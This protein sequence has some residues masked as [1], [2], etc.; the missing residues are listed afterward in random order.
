MSV[1]AARAQSPL[2]R[3]WLRNWFLICLTLCIVAGLSLGG[4]MDSGWHR[5]I[6]SAV[7]G[8][9]P[10]V[11]VAVVLMLMSITLP[12]DDL[13]KALAS[14]GPSVWACLVNLL[15]IPLL[16]WPLSLLQT[17]D[18]FRLGL[19]IAASVPTTMAAASVWTRNAGGNDAVSLL[20]TATTN[21]LCFLVSPFWLRTL[22][23]SIVELDVERLVMSLIISALIPILLGQSL[24]QLKV[25]G[26]WVDA[27]KFQFGIVAQCCILTLVAWAAFQ[28]GPD[29][30]Q[31]QRAGLTGF[32]VVGLCCIALH[33]AGMGI[34]IMGCRGAG[35]SRR[36]MIAVAFAGSQKT[37]PIG[38]L[39]SNEV[40][41]PLALFPML[42]FHASQ[43]FI[44]TPIAMRFAANAETSR[45][46]SDKK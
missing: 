38:I 10:K 18:D 13:K 1:P 43:L 32:A 41:M 44:D 12:T 39:L 45:P 23:G 28:G 42:M 19:L 25:V 35:F 11:M 26:R 34:A 29:F 8:G 21:S 22:G 15:I 5:R 33:L 4:G 6:Q 9:V 40:G 36:D 7:G 20:V 16:A 46:I 2:R 31:G 37:L 24:R 14:P 17:T 3:F 30:A 27:R